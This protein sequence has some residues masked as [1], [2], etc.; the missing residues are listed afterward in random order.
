M[1]RFNKSYPEIGLT[2]DHSSFLLEIFMDSDQKSGEEGFA[3]EGCA[4]C[5]TTRHPSPHETA[6]TSA[7]THPKAEAR[8]PSMARTSPEFA[9]ALTDNITGGDDML[10]HKDFLA[11]ATAA[12]SQSERP[13]FTEDTVCYMA[14]DF[15]LEAFSDRC[16]LYLFTRLHFTRQMNHITGM[17]MSS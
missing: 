10:A 6:P 9:L 14:K 17:R 11:C 12:V 3:K 2:A 5:H 16:Q 15:V 4:F 8:T 13:D 7:Q 1:A